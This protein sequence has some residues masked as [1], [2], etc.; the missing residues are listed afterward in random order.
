MLAPAQFVNTWYVK[1]KVKILG[2]IVG[3]HN[4]EVQHAVAGKSEAV[5]ALSPKAVDRGREGRP[6]AHPPAHPLVQIPAYRPRRHVLLQLFQIVILMC[7][8][9]EWKGSPFISTWRCLLSEALEMV[10]G[11]SAPWRPS[12][13]IRYVLN[14][15]TYQGS[16][17]STGRKVLSLLRGCADTLLYS[18]QNVLPWLTRRTFF[19]GPIRG[20]QAGGQLGPVGRSRL[21]KPS[22]FWHSVPCR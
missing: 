18:I 14:Y 6:G 20:H 4:Q 15:L 7:S 11:P 8:L 5:A 9:A 22:L 19:C 12:Y 17:S 2:Q 1:E 16:S 13:W 10:S 3:Q 21:F